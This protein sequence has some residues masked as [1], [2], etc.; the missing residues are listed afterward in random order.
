M[1]NKEVYRGSGNY[2]DPLEDMLRKRREEMQQKPQMR[3]APRA[4]MRTVSSPNIKAGVTRN[5]RQPQQGQVRRPVRSAYPTNNPPKQIRSVDK[6]R[7]ANKSYKDKDGKAKGFLKKTAVTFLAA[8]ALTTG[9]HSIGE[10]K[11]H[12]EYTKDRDE[13]VDVVVE[14]SD[15]AFWEVVMAED[16]YREYLEEKIDD[17]ASKEPNMKAFIKESEPSDVATLLGEIPQDRQST[18]E[19]LDALAKYRP[20]VAES[21]EKGEQIQDMSQIISVASF[22]SDICTTKE[23]QEDLVTLFNAIVGHD[24][25]NNSKVALEYGIELNE[26]IKIRLEHDTPED[27]KEN[28]RINDNFF[29]GFSSLNNRGS[30]LLTYYDFRDMRL[31][32]INNVL[33]HS[34][35]EAL[36][37]VFSKYANASP[38]SELQEYLVKTPVAGMDISGHFSDSGSFK[39]YIACRNDYYKE[40]LG[41]MADPEKAVSELDKQNADYQNRIETQNRVSSTDMP[42]YVNGL[43]DIFVEYKENATNLKQAETAVKASQGKLDKTGFNDW[44][45]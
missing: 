27:L 22:M 41:L 40:V 24:S 42:A 8:L 44:S 31:E 26:D 16:D 34:V 29:S 28:I 35:N 32:F 6:S 2:M 18:E 10:A 39:E 38:T 25:V 4:D 21:V 13:I 20:Y 12:F 37:S 36:R 5:S 19:V 3:Q 30:Y 9:I 23:N 45:R 17:I 33:N 7:H 43:V 11:E 15:G 1:S 14:Q